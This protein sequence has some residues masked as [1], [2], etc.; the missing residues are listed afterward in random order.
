MQFHLK[1]LERNLAG[2]HI[3]GHQKGKTNMRRGENLSKMN[4]YK[5]KGKAID[6]TN[7]P[8]M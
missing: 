4:R 8:E 7:S 3:V 2:L 5:D 6:M 1:W